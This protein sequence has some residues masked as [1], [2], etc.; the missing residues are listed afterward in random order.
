VIL[1]TY[2][3]G[4]DQVV[5]LPDSGFFWE[6]EEPGCDYVGRMKWV[7]ENQ[8][9]Q[10]KERPLLRLVTEYVLNMILGTRPGLPLTL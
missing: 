8:L 9:T 3:R 2:Y 10:G 4:D 5:G 7:F 1:W 6:H